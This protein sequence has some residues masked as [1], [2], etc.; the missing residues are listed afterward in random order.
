MIVDDKYLG[1]TGKY[2]D[3][4][5]EIPSSELSCDLENARR[6]WE[7]SSQICGIE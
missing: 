4:E 6:L 7:H 5:R 2:I 3:R 1:L